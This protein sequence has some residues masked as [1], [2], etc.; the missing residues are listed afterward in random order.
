MTLAAQ[1]PALQRTPLHGMHVALGA[2]MGPFGGYE[3]PIRYPSGI[4]KEHLH[5]RA[6]ASLFDVSHM[7]QIVLRPD[8]GS[9]ADVAL[10]LERL[11]PVDVLGL[12]AGRQ[13]Y[14]FFTNTNGGIVD[15]LMIAHG[16]DHFVLL[17]NASQKAI[18]EAYL[19]AS[20]ARVCTVEVWEGRA[21]LALQGPAAHAVLA[22]LAPDSATMHFMDVRILAIAGCTCL[23]SRSGYTGE[24][25]FE[26]SIAAPRAEDLAGRC[27]RC[28]C[29]SRRPRQLTD[30]GWL[31]PLWF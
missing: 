5:T 2:Q 8:S 25:G 20:M 16:D 3:M 1:S 9:L 15:D 13:R 18:D 28:I 11:V 17:V 31:V 10:A 22:R 12:A 21:L 24:D 14:A 29:R 7:G 23:V 19:R 27:F 30:R 26:I 4:M 6:A